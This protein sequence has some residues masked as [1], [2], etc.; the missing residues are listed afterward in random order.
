[1][2]EVKRV[3]SAAGMKSRRGQRHVIGFGGTEI[4]GG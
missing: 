1:M 2:T 3:S 4:I